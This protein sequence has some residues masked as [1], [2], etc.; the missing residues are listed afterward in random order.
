[1]EEKSKD[2]VCKTYLDYWEEYMELKIKQERLANEIRQRLLD[3]AT[4]NP[5]AIITEMSNTKIKAKSIAND[6][7]I[8]NIEILICIL[9]IQRIEDWIAKQKETPFPS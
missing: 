7:Y 3:I 2:N 5:D 6:K 4:A 1:M 9:Y 8:K